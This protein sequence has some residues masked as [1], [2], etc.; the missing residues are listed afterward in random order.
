MVSVST[1][2]G[3]TRLPGNPLTMLRCLSTVKHP[4]FDLGSFFSIRQSVDAVWGG[5]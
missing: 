3:C 5:S 4:R 2:L 1:G